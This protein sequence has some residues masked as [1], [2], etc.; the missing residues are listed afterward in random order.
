MLE[1]GRVLE[2]LTASCQSCLQAARVVVQL[3]PQNAPTLAD[4]S[5]TLAPPTSE[6]IAPHELN[7]LLL[8]AWSEWR[9]DRL[10]KSAD[11][12]CIKDLHDDDRSTLRQPCVKSGTTCERSFVEPVVARPANP[13]GLNLIDMVPVVELPDAKS[14]TK[15]LLSTI[16]IRKLWRHATLQSGHLLSI[17]N[18]VTFGGPFSALA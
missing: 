5:P 11:E 15:R 6:S 7:D 1:G 17:P 4:S 3:Y 9:L 16:E 13:R 2:L 10:T 14:P 18:R 12:R 8:E